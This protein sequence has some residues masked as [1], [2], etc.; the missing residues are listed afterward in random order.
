MTRLAGEIVAFRGGRKHFVKVLGHDVFTML[1]K[2]HHAHAQM[3]QQTRKERRA[4]VRTLERDVAGMQAG[5]RHAHALM[6]RQTRA[7]RRA[8]VA[9][10]KKTVAG[11]RLEFVTDIKGA[12][13]AWFGPTPAER[14][15][16]EAERRA[17][18]EAEQIKKAAERDRLAALAMA[19]EEAV[20]HHTA[21]AAKEET[22]RPGKKKG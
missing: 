19:K 13:R 12:H 17:K 1:T 10:L 9:H 22:G 18:A 4:F 16:Q 14:R 2:F 3:A 6:A 8:A 7:E 11:L 5:F 15:A 20:R 21:P